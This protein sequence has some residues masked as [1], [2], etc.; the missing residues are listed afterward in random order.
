MVNNYTH[1]VQQYPFLRRFTDGQLIPY[2]PE[3]L[4]IESDLINLPWIPIPNK[5]I[6]PDDWELFWKL[7]NQQRSLSETRNN[8]WEYKFIWV[9]PSLNRHQ[10][11][12]EYTKITDSNS[13]TDWSKIFPK[14]FENLF[15]TLNFM[16][17]HKIS[18]ARNIK[19]VPCHID[20]ITRMYPFPNTARIMLWDSNPNP[21]FYLSPWEKHELEMPIISSSEPINNINIMHQARL[22]K[23]YVD[24][25]SDTNTFL[26]TNGQYLH[27]A[28]TGT[29]KI[30]MLIWSTPNKKILV[31]LLRRLIVHYG[32]KYH[33]TQV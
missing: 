19:P 11:E 5:K 17:I 24:L 32:R 3:I 20:P 7:W 15:D 18:I 1:L 6:E 25:P 9:N 30:I 23:I 4:E 27:G 28:D 8:I 16:D 12:M 31:D 29:G 10:I 2:C 14:M 21:T 22:N 26:Y 33:E 13:V